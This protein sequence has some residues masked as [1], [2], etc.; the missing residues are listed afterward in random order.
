MVFGHQMAED[1]LLVKFSGIA[2]RFLRKSVFSP[3][4]YAYP[5]D[6]HH[7]RRVPETEFIEK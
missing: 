7:H 6:R 1:I 4:L 5:V 3:F 2:H